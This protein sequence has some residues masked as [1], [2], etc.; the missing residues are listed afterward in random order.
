MDAYDANREIT[1][2]VTIYVAEHLGGVEAELAGLIVEG[3]AADKLE[4]LIVRSVCARVY[5][6]EIDAIV[7][8]A[9]KIADDVARSGKA[10]RRL[11]IAEGVGAKSPGKEI[12][13]VVALD[14]I[15]AIASVKMIVAAASEE[16]VIAATTFE[17]VAEV[18]PD[19]SVVSRSSVERICLIEG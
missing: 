17:I 14:E 13:A 9:G 2:P 10:V 8:R 15:L 12:A 16:P 19:Q 6:G 3:A 11:E 1:V 5:V 18:L 7:L 4:G